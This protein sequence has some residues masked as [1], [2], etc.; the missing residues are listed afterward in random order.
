VFQALEKK[1]S[2]G[3]DEMRTLLTQAHTQSTLVDDLRQQLK[4][5][6]EEKQRLRDHITQLETKHR[7][8]QCKFSGAAHI[9]IL[10]C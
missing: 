5:A 4:R 7:D 6:D 10:Q 2:G 9:S 3:E 8:R 1:Q